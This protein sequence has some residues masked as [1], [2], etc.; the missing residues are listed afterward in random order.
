MAKQTGLGDNLYVAGYN[1]SGDVGAVNNIHGGP[2]LLDVTAIDKSAYERLG[3]VRDGGLDFSGF[4]NDATDQLHTTVSTLPTADVSVMYCRGTAI[5]SPA[6]SCVA[7]QINYD[8]TRG[9]DGSL[10]VAVEI[11]ANGFG[12]EWGKQLTAGMVSISSAGDQASIDQGASSSNGAQAYLQV[13]SLTGTSATVTVEDSADDAAF[14]TLL[15]FTAATD[16]TTERVAV[17][18]AVDRY[19]R[20][21]VAGTFTEFS[22]AVMFVRNLTAVAF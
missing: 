3:G 2:S 14:A 11:Q 12:L 10:T 9:T 13:L 19:I 7:K 17:T 5:G 8:L 18:G 16:T 6:A 15:S 4:F 1:V 22:F 20:A 21:S